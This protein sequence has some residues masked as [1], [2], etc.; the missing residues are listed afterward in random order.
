M[1]LLFERQCISSQRD[2]PTVTEHRREELFGRVKFYAP[3][4]SATGNG[5]GASNPSSPKGSG[6][7][8]S[9]GNETRSGS[10]SRSRGSRRRGSGSR[11]RRV[12]GNGYADG[13]PNGFNGSKRL[14]GSGNGGSFDVGG[15]SET[16]GSPRSGSP[17]GGEGH[18]A[19]GI[20]S[21]SRSRD[22]DR[23]GGGGGGGGGGDGLV[24]AGESS[25][26]HQH[27]SDELLTLD[28][29]D[30]MRPSASRTRAGDARPFFV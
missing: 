3:P 8:R 16:G 24:H 22:R 7:G 4:R 5:N 17:R 23:G 10:G 20:R 2:L 26:E 18:N 9:G 19:S 29:Q 6:A 30:L 25:L 15:G 14:N 27:E 13:S 12:T 21:R 11:E 28:G 1:P